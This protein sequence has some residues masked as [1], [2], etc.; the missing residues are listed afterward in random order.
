MVKLAKGSN[1]RR[2]DFLGFCA[3]AGVLPAVGCG[4]SGEPEKITKPAVGKFGMV[5]RLEMLQKKAAE[6][7]TP[8]KRA[9]R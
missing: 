6:A 4:G 1:V 2:R 7:P 5:N 3:L 8:K 9:R